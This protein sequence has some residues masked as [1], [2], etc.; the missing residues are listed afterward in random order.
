[1][2]IHFKNQ[3]KMSENIELSY[4]RDHTI[5]KILLHD[6]NSKMGNMIK[7][8]VV[9]NKLEDFNSLLKYT[10]DDFTPTGKLCYM[11]ENGEKLHRKLMKQFFNLR[12]YIQH[13]VD[14]YEYQYGDNEWTNPLHESNWTYRTNKQFMKYVNFTLKEMTPEQMKI[15]PIKPIIKVNTNEE[16]DTEEGES[17]T[18]EQESTISNNEDEYSTFSDMSKQDSESDINVGDTQYQEN[19]YTPELQVYNTYNITMHDKNDLIHDKNDTSEDENTIEIETFE[20]YGEK[21]HETEESIPTETSQVLTVFN[22][23]IHHEDDSSD[24][25]SVI[26]T[27]S[28]Q[29]NGEQ[30]NGKQ[31]KLLTTTFQIEIE[32]RKVEGLTTYSTDQQIFKFKVNSWGVNIEFTLYELKWT[33]HAILQHMGFYHTTE[34]PC[35]IMRANHKTKSRECIILHQDELYIASSTIKEILHILKEKYQIKI[36]S[37]D[38]LESNFPYD[39]G[40]T[41]IC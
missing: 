32:N 25:K 26:E 41:M 20:Q 11:N 18:H 30:E 29:E 1:M 5:S 31:Y 38:Y 14:E 22:K 3:N 24:D 17:N 33:I 19:S 36:N 15:K 4:A 9:F 27:E 39:P 6:L 21:I 8:W 40:G 7:E 35:V 2:S 23:A 12:W 10:D 37:N 16:L 13:L 34:N 28:P